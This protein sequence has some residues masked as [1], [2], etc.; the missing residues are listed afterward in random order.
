MLGAVRGLARGRRARPRWFSGVAGQDRNASGMSST[1]QG[2]TDGATKTLRTSRAVP[3]D[4]LNFRV[5][6]YLG[7]DGGLPF[8]N[9]HGQHPAQS[10]VELR[11]NVGDLLLTKEQ[12]DRLKV[13]V[14]PRLKARTQELVLTA[15]HF[16]SRVDNKRYLIYLLEELVHEAQQSNEEVEAESMAQPPLWW[17]K[18]WRQPTRSSGGSKTAGSASA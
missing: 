17:G 14:G 18:K 3:V 13:L 10:K 1:E 15:D 12:V 2:P 9:V 5:R 16:P 11:V 7:G 6:S 8:A 4:A